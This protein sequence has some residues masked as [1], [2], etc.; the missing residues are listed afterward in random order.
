MVMV[1]HVRQIELAVTGSGSLASEVVHALAVAANGPLTIALLGRDP[2]RLAW[3][4]R[5]ASARAAAT[6]GRLRVVTAATNWSDYDQ[7]CRTIASLR[8]KVLLH[9]ASLQSPWTLGGND[10][11]SSLI[12][13]VGYGFTLPLQALLA[14]RVSRAI[15]SASPTTCMVNACYPDAVNR[16]LTANGARVACGIGN[17]AIL[18][19]LL[20]SELTGVEGRRLRVIAHHAH[21]SA[22]INGKDLEGSPARA[23]VDAEPINAEVT[24]LLRESRLPPHLNSITGAAAVPM[25]LALLGRR[26]SWEGHA[27]GPL[28]LIG[29]YPVVVTADSVEI[30]LPSGVGL[31]EAIAFNMA[32]ANSDGITVMENGELVLSDAAAEALKQTAGGGDTCSQPWHAADVEQQAAHL[33]ALRESLSG[34]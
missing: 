1:A 22:A 9:T 3:L 15:A 32:A 14:L 16:V 7:L 4:A 24:R 11:W 19:A 13:R 34:R 10:R 2:A 28:G 18:A 8:P 31:A 6:G 12:G 21:V 23:W 33:L 30:D 26:A 27:A 25:L 17:V 29:G 5:A 20:L